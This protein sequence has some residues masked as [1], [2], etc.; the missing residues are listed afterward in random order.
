ML[1]HGELYYLE[2]VKVTN[3]SEQNKEHV[4]ILVH[5]RMAFGDGQMLFGPATKLYLPN[6]VSH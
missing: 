5:M 1:W 2:E 3:N 4:N 6:K